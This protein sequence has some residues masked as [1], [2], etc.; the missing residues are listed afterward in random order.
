MLDMETIP[1]KARVVLSDIARKL[2]VSHTTVSRALR[3]DRQIS[4]PLCQRVQRTAAEM[5]YRPDAML[6]ALAHYRRSSKAIP[7]AAE[8]AWVNHLPGRGG[9]RWLGG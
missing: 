4:R 5:G 6:T 3:N 7:G 8:I 2:N 1:P 9:L